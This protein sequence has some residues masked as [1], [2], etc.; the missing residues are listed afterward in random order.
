MGGGDLLGVCKFA[1]INLIIPNR[2]TY[3][4]ET[5]RETSVN[6]ALQ[7]LYN[8]DPRMSDLDLFYGKVS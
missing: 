7:S 1:F 3:D 2:K 5:L 6:R 4:F 8:H